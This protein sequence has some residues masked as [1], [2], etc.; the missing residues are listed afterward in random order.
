MDDQIHQECLQMFQNISIGLSKNC[1]N[2][3][4]RA[5]SEDYFQSMADCF[6]SWIPFLR[7][8]LFLSQKNHFFLILIH[9]KWEFNKKCLIK[10]LFPPSLRMEYWRHVQDQYKYVTHMLTKNLTTFGIFC[11]CDKMLNSHFF[12]LVIS[13]LGATQISG[14]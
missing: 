1:S 2:H 4:K 7:T 3:K 12:V 9:N 10:L 5:K 8:F 6:S 14:Q 13:W 11:S